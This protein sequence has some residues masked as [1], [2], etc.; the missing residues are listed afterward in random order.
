MRHEN[1]INVGM[2]S[3]LRFAMVTISELKKHS[4]DKK[5]RDLVNIHIGNLQKLTNICKY[6]RT[7]QQFDFASNF[8]S[9]E[10]QLTKA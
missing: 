7:Q 10:K 1:L 3:S 8:K 2:L 9:T 4:P 6:Y 5:K